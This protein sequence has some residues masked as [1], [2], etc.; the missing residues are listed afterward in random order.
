MPARRSAERMLRDHEIH[1]DDQAVREREP[2]DDLRTER[3]RAGAHGLEAHS[4]ERDR[5]EDLLPRLDRSQRRP[6]DAGAVERRAD[7]VVHRD[8]DDPSVERHDRRSPNGDRAREEER[9]V[10]RERDRRRHSSSV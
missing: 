7:S 9:D 2:V 4:S 6:V 10:D 3:Q 1:C 8:A 5:E